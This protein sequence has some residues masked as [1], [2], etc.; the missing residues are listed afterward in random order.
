M[1]C[2]ACGTVLPMRCTRF[3][4]CMLAIEFTLRSSRRR[5][6]R[7]DSERL[8][9]ASEFV[10]LICACFLRERETRVLTFRR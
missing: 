6:P 7:A 4:V 9:G 5:W 1:A 3:F 10:P 2:A 8:T